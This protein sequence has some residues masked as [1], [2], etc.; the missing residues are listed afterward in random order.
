[1]NEDEIL[2]FSFR[3]A[4][5]PQRRFGVGCPDCGE[6]RT[7]TIKG[8]HCYLCGYR[9][10]GSESSQ[11]TGVL[12]PVDRPSGWVEGGLTNPHPGG[13]WKNIQEKSSGWEEYKKAAEKIAK[14]QEDEYK[15]LI[16]EIEE[17][18]EAHQTKLN[19]L[20]KKIIAKR[21][22]ISYVDDYD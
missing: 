17:E 18:D 8:N 16:S 14:N 13:E 9:S 5:K 3:S 7:G 1:M 12:Q 2:E 20:K 10:A 21:K 4:I 15:K 6:T 19:D 22:G 11:C